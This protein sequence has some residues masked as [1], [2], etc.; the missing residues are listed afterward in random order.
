MTLAAILL[1]ALTRAEIIQRMR[2]PIITQADGLVKVYARCDEDVRREYQQPVARYAADTVKMLYQH[3]LKKGERFAQP[4]IVI[5]LGNDRTNTTEVVSEVITNDVQMAVSRILLKNPGSADLNRL[6]LEVVKGFYRSVEGKE[7]GDEA[8]LAILRAADPHYRIEDERHKLELWLKG[9]RSAS[10]RAPTDEEE[11]FEEVE[12]NLARMRKVLQPGTA[13]KRDVLTFG[14]HLWLYARTLDEKFYGGA[15]AVS[16]KDAISLAKFDPRVRILA[17]FK[18]RELPVLA[19][20]RGEYLAHAAEAYVHFL[21]ELAKGEK[22]EAELE[23]LYEIA[24]LKLKA[25]Y[26][27]AE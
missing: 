8:A 20:G 3:L 22:T 6:R 12:E 17:V 27:Q 26:S 5:F 16:F 14:S 2:A 15:S 4:G 18:M 13:S 25:A 1:F 21:G 24:E 19:G 23:K 10:A 7:L 11:L 9:E